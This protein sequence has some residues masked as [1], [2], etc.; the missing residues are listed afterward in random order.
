MSLLLGVRDK[1]LIAHNALNDAKQL[2]KICV[3][4]TKMFDTY[5]RI[6]RIFEED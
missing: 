1:Q 3:K 4:I 2:A 5:C 6:E